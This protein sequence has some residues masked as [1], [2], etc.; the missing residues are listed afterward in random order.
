MRRKRNDKK[1]RIRKIKIKKN[2]KYNND[3]KIE[4]NEREINIETNNENK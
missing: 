2:K 4:K 3:G 1:I